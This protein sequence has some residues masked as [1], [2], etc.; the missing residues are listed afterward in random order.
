MP[1]TCNPSIRRERPKVHFQV[2]DALAV[3]AVNKLQVHLPTGT[4][5]SPGGGAAKNLDW[6]SR[7]SE[8]PSVLDWAAAAQRDL[9]P[10]L[11][12]PADVGVQG[13]DEL[14]DASWTASRASRRTRSSGDRRSLRTLHCPAS[15]P[16]VTSS[17]PVGPPRC[18]TAN[19]AS[20]SAR[21][22]RNARRVARCRRSRSRW[23]HPASC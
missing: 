18:G 22:D 16:C 8:S 10:C 13:R 9:D 11:V 2:A 12:V 17:E 14:L 1:E 4:Q 15:T 5:I 20:G 7:D 6:L 23:P 21:R 3:R 19:Q